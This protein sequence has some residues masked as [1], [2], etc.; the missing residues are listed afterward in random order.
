M[1]KVDGPQ[2]PVWWSG[3]GFKQFLFFVYLP[4]AA[5]HTDKSVRPVVV[6]GHVGVGGELI[7]GAS[8]AVIA[9]VIFWRFALGPDG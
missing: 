8:P 7:G 6:A 2:A 5:S 4:G 9:K 3:Q 1:L